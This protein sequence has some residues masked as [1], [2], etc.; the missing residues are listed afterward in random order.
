MIPMSESIGMWVLSTLSTQVYYA[1]C[2]GRRHGLMW[3]LIVVAINVWGLVTFKEPVDPSSRY[4]LFLSNIVNVSTMLAIGY[5]D[6]H[7]IKTASSDEFLRNPKDSVVISYNQVMYKIILYYSFFW[8]QVSIALRLTLSSSTHL[9]IQ[10]AVFGTINIVLLWFPKKYN[11]HR[12]LSVLFL[13]CRLYDHFMCHSVVM[14][15]DLFSLLVE[16]VML[17]PVIAYFIAGKIPGFVMTLAML[18]EILYTYFKVSY[19]PGLMDL[20]VQ[21]SGLITDHER[22]VITIV[23]VTHT[24]TLS[25]LAFISEVTRRSAFEISIKA[26]NQYRAFSATTTTENR[27]L[28]PMITPQLQVTPEPDSSVKLPK[29]HGYLFSLY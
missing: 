14:G 8:T 4:I 21:T 11:L 25:F 22:L 9:L 28:L 19:D 27:P 2:L 15:D 16:N 13:V 12:G 6:H 3:Y 1:I 10:S 18:S 7:Y 17:Q 29:A 24:I 26:Y 20:S 23:L 5:M